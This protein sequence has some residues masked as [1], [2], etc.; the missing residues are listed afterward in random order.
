MELRKFIEKTVKE[1]LN[2]QINT[3]MI[4]YYGKLTSKEIE[5]L[6]RI[7]RRSY[8]GSELRPIFYNDTFI[9]GISWNLGGIDYI[10]FLPEFINKGYLKYIV[11]DNIDNNNNVIFVSASDKLKKQLSNYGQVFYDEDTDHTIVKIDDVNKS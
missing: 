9:G 5:W 6:V 3:D 1:F 2:E 7:G 10:E 8:S 11:Y 4:K